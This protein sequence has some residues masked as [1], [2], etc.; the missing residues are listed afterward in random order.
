MAIIER[1]VTVYNDKGSKQAL[2]DLNKLEDSFLNAGK[3][4]A[5]AFGAAAFAAGA[6]AT[7]L[8]VDGVQAAVADQKSQALLA[9][10]LKT[11]AGASAEAIAGVEGYIA[12][13][14][15]AVSVTDDEL[16]PSLA[17]LVR[18]TNDV[19][20]A[21]KLQALALDISAGTGR[22]LQ[23]V[24]LSLAKAISGNFGALT[25]LGVPLSDNIK[26]SKDLNAAFS[27]LSKTYGGAASTRAQTFEYRLKGISI[28]FN[29]VLETLGYALLPVL[30]DFLQFVQADLIPQLEQFVTLNKDKIAN[31]LADF[32]KFAVKATKAV[33]A[34][35]E[36]ISNN[37][38]AFKAFAAILVGT[39]VGGKVYAGVKLLIAAVTLLT[40]SFRKQAAAGTAAGIATA[41]ATGGTSAVAAAAGLAAFAV[42]AG[43]AFIAL[44]KLNSGFKDTTTSIDKQSQVVK[45][46]LADLNRLAQMTATAT[47]GTVGADAKTS[48][49]AINA[50]AARLNLIR[51]GRIEEAARVAARQAEREALAQV[52][53]EGQ[54]YQDILQVLADTKITSEEI[55]V[56]AARWGMTVDAVKN[57]VAQFFAVADKKISTSEI[58]VLASAWGLSNEQVAKYLD[59]VQA[60]KDGKLTSEEISALQEKWG[61]TVQEITQYADFVMKLRDFKVTDEEVVALGKAWGLTNAEVL[62]YF[63]GIG[64]PFDYKGTFIDPIAG[65]PTIWTDSTGAVDAYI[66]AVGNADD[67]LAI[68]A[69]NAAQNGKTVEDALN[70][71]TASATALASASQTSLAIASEANA[72]AEVARATAALADAEAT[73][74]QAAAD[75]AL[76]AARAAAAAASS[77]AGIGG[78]PNTNAFVSP[79]AFGASSTIG[80]IGRGEYESGVF[81]Q[82]AG[83]GTTV[84][85]TVNGSMISQDDLIST[86]R[87]GLLTGIGSGQATT[88]DPRIIKG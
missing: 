61:M 77:V 67:A 57:Y 58:E 46:H 16:R 2:K 65:I 88:Y 12:A 10:A 5:K 34:M 83:Q 42:A 47:G 52:I 78:G 71:A 14:Q 36:G 11:T 69:K 17:T 53:A 13:T 50:E 33:V 41:F 43:T 85:V 79:G 73:A 84:N 72:V 23:T 75:A 37:I 1:I 31:A 35:F 25:K 55:A 68:L 60:L 44:N 4:I 28:A 3:N 56:L 32:A 22:D 86:V 87:D 38:G 63:A 26:K 27:E 64:V 29:E 80:A 70:A 39:F 54:K 20:Q 6:L 62:A 81:G 15:K 8:A 30:E 7:K 19:A 21:Q 9:Q 40:A 24:S 49:E 66:K 82:G 18:A 74:A 76:A 45:G 48:Q 51:E 59:F